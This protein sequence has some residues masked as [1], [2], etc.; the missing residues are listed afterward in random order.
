MPKRILS[1]KDGS[2]A[3]RVTARWLTDWKTRSDCLQDAPLTGPRSS[4]DIVMVAIITVITDAE[5]GE[6]RLLLLLLLLLLLCGR[7]VSGAAS[8]PS[9]NGDETGRCVGILYI[10]VPKYTQI[11]KVQTSCV[12]ALT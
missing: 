2:L 11:K 8:A 9:H 12:A 1:K 3:R 10:P 6:R 7:L 5:M 4:N